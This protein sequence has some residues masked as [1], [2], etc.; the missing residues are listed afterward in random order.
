MFPATA[1]GLPARRQGPGGRAAVPQ[2]RHGQG[3]PRAAA[4]RRRRRSTAARSGG[5]SSPRPSDPQHR[6]RRERP[7]RADHRC[8][9]SRPTG[10][11]TAGADATRATAGWT[12]TAWA[13]RAPAA[14]PWARSSTCS[15][16]TTS[17]PAR[18]V[19]RSSNARVPAPVQRGVRD[20]V[21]R[22]QPLV[23]D[24]PGVP[25]ARAAQPGLRGRAGL[26]V[27]PRRRAQPRPIA[28]R[29]PGRLVRR[30]RRA[31]AG[32][33][34]L[35]RDG[36][37]DDAPVGRRP[38]GQRRRRTPPPSS[39]PAAPASPCRAAG[40]L[41]NNE[42]TD[43]NFVPLSAGVPDPNLPGPGKRPRS[44]M[45]PTIVLEDGRP[46]LGARQPGRRHDHHHGRPG[47]HRVPRPRTCPWSTP[48][49][50]R[51]C[52]RA[53]APRTPSRRCSARRTAA[54]LQAQ[55]HVLALQDPRSAR[56][57]RSGSRPRHGFEAAAETDPSRRRLGD[58]GAARAAEPAH[59]A[60]AR[61][62]SRIRKPLSEV[63]RDDGIRLAGRAARSSQRCSESEP[64]FFC[65]TR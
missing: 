39:R 63:N 20:R 4:A 28:V 41:L 26:P 62:T 30:V 7:A 17:R 9:T 56:G 50:R 22:P 3:L 19:A 8:A 55:G 32:S 24:V 6:T 18:P 45:S 36:H 65:T 16:P 2:P 52:P 46:M 1:A 53:T 59:S 29:Q 5:P 31:G 34:R 14:S 37:V 35:P 64:R 13:C 57:R 43:F 40:F 15:R 38:L 61:R 10:R 48:S 44:S 33:S 47:A 12:S 27:H 49:P 25:D 23:G 51:G 54:A 58:G 42:L 11:W 60:Q 21:R